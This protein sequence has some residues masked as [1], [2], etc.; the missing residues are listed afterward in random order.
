MAA[1]RVVRGRR[2]GARGGL[3]RPGDRALD[4][5]HSVAVHRGR[6]A[7]VHPGRGELDTR[8]LLRDHV[9]G[10]RRRRDRDERRRSWD[11]AYRLLV[12]AGVEGQGPHASRA[13]SRVHARP[14][15]SRSR[16]ARVVHRTRE[17]RVTTRGREGGFPEGGCPPLTHAASGR[18]PTGLCD[19]LAVTRRASST[20]EGCR[21]RCGRPRALAAVES[22]TRAADGS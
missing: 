16:P 20:D 2:A 3:Q 12:R 17:P 5:G 22:A 9:P 1:L 18:E 15:A 10:D 8:A 11:R 13:S 4:S 14:R 19:V 21:G 7:R 6:R